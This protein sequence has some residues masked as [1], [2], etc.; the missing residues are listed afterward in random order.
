MLKFSKA[1][2]KIKALASVKPL[3]QFLTGNR[4]VYSYDSGLSGWTC[5]SAKD[6]LAKVVI[7]ETGK[8]KVVDGPDMQFRCFSASQ[9]A[10]FT[11][12]YNSRKGNFDALRQAKTTE[13]MAML[14]VNSIPDDCG[15]VRIN[16]AGDIFSQAYFDAIILAANAIPSVLFYAYTKSLNFWVSRLGEIPQNLVLTASWGGRYDSLITEHGLR[17]AKVVFSVD[18]AKTLGLEIDGDDSHAADPTKR[19]R[20]FALLIHGQQAAGSEASK[21]LKA[22][23][24]K[25]SYGRGNN[26]TQG[27]IAI[28]NGIKGKAQ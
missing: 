28:F 2:A 23:K 17:S 6:C 12:V 16:V 10:L 21:A 20:D 19:T 22:L 13:N 11:N 5:P 25:G 9:E 4:K 1:N 26:T 18:E 24:G 3:E 15:I 27:A 8:R 7:L 14:L